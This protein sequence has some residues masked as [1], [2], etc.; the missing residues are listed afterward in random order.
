[1]ASRTQETK[2]KR[3]LRRKKG[4]KDTPYKKPTR[5][6][7]DMRPCKNCKDNPINGGKHL[8][9]DCPTLKGGAKLNQAESGDAEAAMN[10]FNHGRRQC[11][12]R[13]AG[14]PRHAC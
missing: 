2:F 12:L 4:G 3:E 10:L 5:W 8:D 7:N 6:E 14:Q 1:M 13:L 11:A 9:D